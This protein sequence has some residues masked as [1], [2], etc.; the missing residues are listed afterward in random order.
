MYLFFKSPADGYLSIFTVEG[1]EAYRILPY[2]EMPAEYSQHLPIVA[3]TEYL[4]FSNDTEN[5]IY[6]DLASEYTDELVM[7]TDANEEYIDLYV[8][9]STE[10]F[11]KPTLDHSY[12]SEGQENFIP[13]SLPKFEFESWLSENRIRTEN[14]LYKKLRL[15]IYK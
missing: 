8:I 11:I 10:D 4:F 5:K 13:R 15:K 12:Q 2:Q 9:F 6:D 14:F 1:S 7:V 3:D